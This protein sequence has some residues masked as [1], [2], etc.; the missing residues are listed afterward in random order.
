M[1]IGTATN[2][3]STTISIVPRIALLIP[4][5]S[6]RNEPV[7]SVVKKLPADRAEAP[8]EQVVDD[9]HERDERDDRARPASRPRMPL[10]GDGRAGAEIG[11]QSGRSAASTLAPAGRRRHLLSAHAG[12]RVDGERQHE[13][14]EAGGDQ[15]AHV[16][17]VVGRLA[18]LVGD[19]RGER[20]A[21]VEDRAC[22]IYGALPITSVTAI[23]SPIARPRPSIEAP[24]MP[25]ARVR[26]HRDADH[27][28]ARRAQRQRG[29]LVVGRHGAR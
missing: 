16:Q 26:E 20:V 13:Q 15:S 6:P 27:L 3:A 19:H 7:G 22:G 9:Q 10:V 2:V 12:Q 18:E 17:R 8:L 24:T 28:P 11:D 29:L 23:V 4:P 1:P 5:G 21:L 25:L 14:H